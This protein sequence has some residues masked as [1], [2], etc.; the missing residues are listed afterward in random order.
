MTLERNNNVNRIFNRRAAMLGVALLCSVVAAANPVKSMTVRYSDLDLSRPED[1]RRLYQRIQHAALLVC[2]GDDS[3]ETEVQVRFR[4][5]YRQAVDNAVRK[6]GSDKLAALHR[7]GT[8][9]G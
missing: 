6:V 1:A 3:R 9:G 8:N 7:D 4:V 2:A 5:C